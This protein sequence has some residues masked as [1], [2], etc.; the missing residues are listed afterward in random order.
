MG[1]PLG[2][3]RA[4]TRAGEQI[5]LGHQL[6]VSLDHDSARDA[7]LTGQQPCGRQTGTPP[8]PAD[9]DA[10]AQFALDLRAQGTVAIQ[11]DMQIHGRGRLMTRVRCPAWFT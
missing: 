9:A 11:D 10:V 3:A 4:L 8:Q 6:S 1:Q 7:Q 5:A 2:H